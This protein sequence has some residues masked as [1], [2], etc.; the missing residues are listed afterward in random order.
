LEEPPL[1][2]GSLRFPQI[3]L[4]SRWSPKIAKQTRKQ[5]TLKV[6]RLSKWWDW[7]LK[8]FIKEPGPGGSCL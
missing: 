7:I 8:N 5:N 4:H 1:D 3:K 6:V 2:P